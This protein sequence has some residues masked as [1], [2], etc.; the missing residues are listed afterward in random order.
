[1]FASSDVLAEE[2]FIKTMKN[3]SNTVPQKD[4]SS[5]ENEIKY[6]EI[7]QST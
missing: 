3:R 6:H 1:M 5:P 7:L 2:K 4:D